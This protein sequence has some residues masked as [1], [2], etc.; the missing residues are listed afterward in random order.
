MDQLTSA[1]FDR[2][3]R[4]SDLS[5]VVHWNRRLKAE[6]LEMVKA[7]QIFCRHRFRS[8]TAAEKRRFCSRY[9]VQVRT[10]IFQI[11]TPSE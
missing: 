6:G 10:S 2:I 8:F 9:Q 3:S 5:L 4:W 1:L 7:W 11:V